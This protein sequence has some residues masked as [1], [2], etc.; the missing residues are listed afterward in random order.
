V[1]QNLVTKGYPV[2]NKKLKKGAVQDALAGNK[3]PTENGRVS[4]TLSADEIDPI[5]GGVAPAY[6]NKGIDGDDIAKVVAITAAAE[7]ERAAKSVALV[8]ALTAGVRDAS[9]ADQVGATAA[10]VA[11]A[12]ANAAGPSTPGRSGGAGLL[13]V[14]DPRGQIASLGTSA[15]SPQAGQPQLNYAKEIKRL[16]KQLNDVT[17]PVVKAELNYKLSYARLVAGHQ[18]GAI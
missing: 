1:I 10:A 6:V 14:S 5:F 8:N 2:K 15:G 7:V 11:Q 9:Y 12:Q 3:L 18:T 4:G 16:E 13:P 17:D